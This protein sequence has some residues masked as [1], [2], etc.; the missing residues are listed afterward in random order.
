VSFTQ[1]ML[2]WDEGSGFGA[3]GG[4]ADGPIDPVLSAVPSSDR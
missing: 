3:G 4:G 2:L 1:E